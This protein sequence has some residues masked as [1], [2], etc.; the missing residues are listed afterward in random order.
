MITLSTEILLYSNPFNLFFSIAGNEGEKN[1]Y[2]NLF[3]KFPKDRLEVFFQG[4]S[5]STKKEVVDNLE[6]ILRVAIY[7]CQKVEKVVDNLSEHPKG[8]RLTLEMVEEVIA[9]F[10]SKDVWD[11]DT[12]EQKWKMKF[13]TKADG[14]V[15]GQKVL[16]TFLSG[17][18]SGENVER[19]LDFDVKPGFSLH[20]EGQLRDGN[21]VQK[22][23]KKPDGS[24]LI[25]TQQFKCSMV[26]I[27]K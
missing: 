24:F 2:I 7:N 8:R 23:E 10:N 25:E 15:E 9:T 1:C 27:E 3:K 16:L 12:T 6:R 18:N 14:L 19:K 13:L 11:I 20:F 26:I 22:V 4:E 5:F 17:E 21:A